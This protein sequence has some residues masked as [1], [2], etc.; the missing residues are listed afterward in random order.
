MCNRMRSRLL[1]IVLVLVMVLCAGCGSRQHA[2]SGRPQNLLLITMDTTCADHLGCYGDRSA[3]TP[4]LDA[5]AARGA[6]FEQTIALVPLTR[7]SHATIL[8]GLYPQRHGVWSNGPYRLDPKWQTLAEK[9]HQSGFHTGGVIASFVLTR[10]FGFSRGFDLFDD[11]VLEVP[12]A[13]P[14][15]PA[16][17][18]A[19]TASAWLGSALQPP[20]FLWLHFYDPHFPYTPPEPYKSRFTARPYDGEIACMD[21]A[22]GEVLRVLEHGKWLSNTL[23]VAVGDHGEGLG[24]HG[25]ETHGYYLYDSTLKVPLILAGPGVPQNQVISSQVTLADLE[26]TILDALEMKKE[27]DRFDGRS[28]WKGL[29]AG[30]VESNPALIENRTIHYQFGWAALSGIRTDSWKWLN[31]P[32]PELYDLGRDP[33]E[34]INVSAGLE[35]RTAELRKLRDRL[36]PKEEAQEVA[37]GLSPEEEEKLRSLGYLS[38]GPTS[39]TDINT[40]PDPKRFASVLTPIERLI[41]AKQEKRFSDLGLLVRDI[42]AGDPTNLFALRT[43]GELLIEQ[44]KYQEALDVL[45]RLTEARENHPETLAYLATAYEKTGQIDKAL[46]WYQKATTPPWIYWPA[47]ESLARLALQFPE[48]L[49]PKELL[50]KLSG[51]QPDGYRERLSLARAY[52]I[53]S[54]F[55]PAIVWYDHALETNP[56]APE[57]LVGL[58]QMMQKS[59]RY[60]DAL[61]TL[62]RV[63]P[64]TA[65]SLFV[66]GT[67][68]LSQGQKSQACS[69]FVDSIH[70][71]P[72]NP[73][74]LFGLGFNLQQCASVVL[75][76]QAYERVLGMEPDY[77][78]ALYNL[79]QLREQ[80]KDFAKAEALYRRFLKVAPAR[81][82]PQRQYARDRLRSMGGPR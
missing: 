12:G 79:A 39:S 14:E 20:F 16:A 66:L 26:P 41:R 55:E 68:L 67:I 76:I 69:S 38:S 77:A 9:L 37:S 19:R 73:N 80:G 70:Q 36:R 82:D 10:S 24:E 8:T 57:A 60:Q 59:G 44:R 32:I 27:T 21:Q 5:L 72:T 22:I 25:E 75:A 13:D 48:R 3:Q 63:Q 31:A 64:P 15:K 2:T 34:T 81:F 46:L 71:Q 4:N 43:K 53:L 74:L 28:F 62:S 18:V 30:R 23:V 6:R 61:K 35:D 56:Q 40:G 47:L 1:S 42:L 51:F 78:E 17:D 33:H 54:A 45:L 29:Q 52:G 58:A 7:P 65:E 11:R 50:Q 49:N